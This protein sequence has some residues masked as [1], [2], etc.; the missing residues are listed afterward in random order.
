M[1]NER[2]KTNTKS[3][4]HKQQTNFQLVAIIFLFRLNEQ[5]KFLLHK[6]DGGIKRNE[7]ISFEF[8]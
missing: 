1:K 8:R 3:S 2:N 4:K 7:V 5:R 6:S